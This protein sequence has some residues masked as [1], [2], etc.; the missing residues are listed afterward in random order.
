MALNYIW[1]ARA[2]KITYNEVS[3]E[4]KCSKGSFVDANNNAY[5]LNE[6]VCKSIPS[7]H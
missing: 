5:E 2:I 4:L 3:L 7:S 6:L 1:F